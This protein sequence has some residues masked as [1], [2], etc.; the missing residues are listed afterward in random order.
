MLGQCCSAHQ[1]DFLFVAFVVLLWYVCASC[2]RHGLRGQT[3]SVDMRMHRGVGP[4]R[5][6]RFWAP[7]LSY[8]HFG[9]P[10]GHGRKKFS[11]RKTPEMAINHDFLGLRAL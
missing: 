4:T 8:G 10:A 3:K 1:Y 7:K 2:D 5:A 11:S 9:H 6:A